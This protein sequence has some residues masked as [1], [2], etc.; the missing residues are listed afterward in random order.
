MTWL[1][2]K[3][4]LLINHKHTVHSAVI[5]MPILVPHYITHIWQPCGLIK[6]VACFIL[7]Q[8]SYGLNN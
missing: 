8:T 3:K 2:A 7:P 4:I 1:I 6:I 5:Y